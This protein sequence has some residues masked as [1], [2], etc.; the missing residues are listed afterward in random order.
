M[1]FA[2]TAS[3]LE[4]F[5][6]KPERNARIY[7]NKGIEYLEDGFYLA[8]ITSFKIALGLNPNTSS[9][10]PIY[11]NLGNAYLKTNEPQLAQECFE[12]AIMFSPMGFPYYQNL[13]KSYKAQGQLKEKLVSQ[14]YRVDASMK[15]IIIGLIYIE[16]GNLQKGKQI[17]ND[18]ASKEPY[19]QIS[20]AIKSYLQTFPDDL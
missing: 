2:F 18:F 16:Q 1:I 11:N 4:P 17:L 8:A 14:T 3:S 20:P 5:E 12:A 10:S 6:V 19:L 7:N 9:S 13:V 15:P